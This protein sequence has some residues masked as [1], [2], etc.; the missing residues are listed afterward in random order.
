MDERG[1]WNRTLQ[2]RLSRRGAIRGSAMAGLGLAG[3]ALIG[4]GS[5][6]EVAAPAAGTAAAP[7]TPAAGGTAA[8]AQDGAPK[9]GGTFVSSALPGFTYQH[10]D[11]HPAVW[12][13]GFTWPTHSLLVTQDVSSPVQAE[14]TLEPD[15]AASWETPDATTYTFHLAENLNFHDI[16]PANG[17][18]AT[19]EDV[20]FMVEHMN[21][22]EPQFFR[23]H[24]FRGV[25]VETPDDK[26][27]VFKLPQPQAA[28][29]N[30]I[31]TPGTV[32]VPP[33]IYE[34]E[35]GVLFRSGSPFPGTGPFMNQQ[36]VQDQTYSVERNPGYFKEGLPYLDR[37]EHRAYPN[38]EAAWVAF[39]A[40]DIDTVLARSREQYQEALRTEGVVLDSRVT[41]QS[42]WIA[43][44]TEKPPYNDPRVRRAISL[45]T[46]RQ[47]II[48]VAFQGEDEGVM[49]GPGGLTPDVHGAATW[50]YEELKTRPGYRSGAAREEDLAEAKK[51]LDAAGFTGLKSIFKY[52]SHTSA[53]P[54]HDTLMTLVLD[55]L[56]PLGFDFTLD[57]YQYSDTLVNLANRDFDIYFTPQYANGVDP[58]EY[59]EFYFADGA[60]R[61]YGAWKSTAYNDLLAK[62]NAAQSADERNEII[63]QMLAILEEEVPRAATDNWRTKNV[64]WDYLHHYYNSYSGNQNSAELMWVDK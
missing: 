53:W 60:V 28:F 4:C 52:T 7:G 16:P 39:K 26:T 55:A 25:T 21:S 9:S 46:P 33:E 44:H 58:N 22:T 49:M 48:E 12:T 34:Q 56:A 54:Y 61:N 14:W 23:Q 31:T 64:N 51:L 6:D 36:F 63:R 47:E 24:E 18:A 37:I 59:L 29:W 8:A 43:F 57:P 30:R 38:T 17:R 2:R 41:L 27:A 42:E 3:A 15:A 50:T 40:K 62:Q 10:L 19:S 32:L 11:P 45:A 20:K 35:G 13:Q 1:Y 5:E